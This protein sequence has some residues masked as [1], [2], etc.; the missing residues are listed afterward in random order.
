M[1]PPFEGLEP[2]TARKPGEKQCWRD[3]LVSPQQDVKL[4]GHIA[5]QEMG[6]GTNR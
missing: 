2:I 3:K 1:L 4:F 6:T 5:D